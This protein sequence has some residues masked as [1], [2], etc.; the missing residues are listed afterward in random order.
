V[1]RE[2]RR[3]K[4]ELGKGGGYILAPGITV[5]ADAPLELVMAMIEETVKDRERRG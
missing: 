4:R 3:L 1:R 2:V 5:Q